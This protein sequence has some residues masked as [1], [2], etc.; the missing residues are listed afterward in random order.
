LSVT[1]S[2]TNTHFSDTSSIAVDGGGVAVSGISAYSPTQISA[3]FSID[4][5]AAPGVRTVTITSGAEVLTTNF[6]VGAS[7]Q[8]SVSPATLTFSKQAVGSTSAA[9]HFTLTNTG[10]ATLAINSVNA[11]GEFGVTHNCGMSLAINASCTINVT[12]SPLFGGYRHGKVVI[13]D[14]SAGSPH[15]LALT[16]LGEVSVTILRPNRSKRFDTTTITEGSVRTLS[17]A[18][19][20]SKAASSEVTCKAGGTLA[21]S[22]TSVSY[23]V[24]GAVYDLELR[25]G[26]ATPGRHDVR[27]LMREGRLRRS[28][29]IPIQVKAESEDD[30]EDRE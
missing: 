17:V 27:L 22:I 10:S 28:F 7:G 14:D 23:G 16:G 20:A 26:K 11:V 19:P 5:A 29:I 2:G 3:T 8:V 25:P 15:L 21:C 12:F 13:N 18:L 24:S 6:T 4:A 1:T 30:E 9:Q